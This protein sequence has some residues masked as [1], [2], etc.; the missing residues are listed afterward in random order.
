MV[1]N[2]ND[3]GCGLKSIHEYPT[4]E[5]QRKRFLERGYTH[6]SANDV[7]NMYNTLI[8]RNER[9]RVERIEFFDEYEEWV[10]ILRHYCIVCAVKETNPEHWGDFMKQ[11]KFTSQ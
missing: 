11:W 2:L 8:D 10:L 5:S 1:E 4:L 3:R 6:V 7:L 9:T